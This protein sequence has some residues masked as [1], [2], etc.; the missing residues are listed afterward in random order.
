MSA[1]GRITE[2]AQAEEIL[3]SGQ[4]E[5]IMIGRGA[6]RD[7]YWPLRAAHELKAEIEWPKQYSRGKFEN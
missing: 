2:A 1:V 5:I 7:P 4:V 6:L 3:Q